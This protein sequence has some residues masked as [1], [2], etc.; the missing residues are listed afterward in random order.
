MAD[1]FARVDKIH[2]KGGNGQRK[3]KQRDAISTERKLPYGR[4]HTRV[5]DAKRVCSCGGTGFVCSVRGGTVLCSVCAGC[6]LVESG[7]CKCWEEL[8]YESGYRS[9]LTRQAIGK[10]AR[11]RRVPRENAL[12]ANS[13]SSS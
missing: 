7:K 4:P 1:I 2:R 12:L 11:P 9:K 10:Q 13:Q 5:A 3:L 8:Y 6:R